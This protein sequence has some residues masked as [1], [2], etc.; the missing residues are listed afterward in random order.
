MKFTE[1]SY[2]FG[3][4]S[5]KIAIVVVI[6]AGTSQENYE[7][8]IKSVQCYA[9]IQGYDFLRVMDDKFNCNHKDKFFRRHC[10][11]A[12][13]LPKY[14]AILFLDADIGVVNPKKRIEEYMDD[15]IDVTFYDRFYNWEIMAGSYIAR[16][17]PYAVKLLKDFADY[18]YQLP[19]SFHGTDNGAIHLFL[20]K[21]LL[22][23]ASVE[24]ENCE[25]I[26]K[27]SV[28]FVDV[29]T[30]EAC[31]RS[32]FGVSEKFGKVRILK[33]GTGWARDDWLSSGIW[34][35]ERDFML[36]GWKMNQLV[37][38]PEGEKISPT[39]MKTD[40]WYNP[41]LG[42]FDISKCSPQNA[43]W[44]YDV[45]LIGTRQAIEKNL[46]DF[47]K[48]VA[49]EQLKSFSRILNLLGLK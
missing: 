4:K 23:N 32:I 19:N 35:Q 20:A 24:I 7:I 21:Q 40:Q 49:L 31:I 44:Q 12:K 34:N 33:K 1:N 13:I 27:K 48:E 37:E 5:R 45:R 39:R 47:E 28:D 16:N 38:V 2:N 43:T 11:A 25:K 30:Y 10:V 17:T 6:T 8:A 36:H 42:P 3:A 26:Y 18:E 41:F 46:L 22:P 29:F 14:D 15:N 9:K